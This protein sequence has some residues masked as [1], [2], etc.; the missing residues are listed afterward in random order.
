MQNFT[1]IQGTVLCA[2]VPAVTLS[3]LTAL[4]FN[5]EI[6]SSALASSCVRI[7]YRRLC[8]NMDAANVPLPDKWSPIS[9]PSSPALSAMVAENQL[10]IG[11][12]NSTLEE[13]LRC[14]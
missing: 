5:N 4:L 13:V 6:V 1:C 7:P 9:S 11:R 14:L 8:L 2:V 3:V 10:A 12:M